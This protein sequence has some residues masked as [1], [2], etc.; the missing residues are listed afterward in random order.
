MSTAIT[1]TALEAS[2]AESLRRALARLGGRAT[3]GDVMT[4]TGLPHSD[5]ETGLKRL[6]E[7]HQG[8]VEVGERGDVVYAFQPR[9]LRRDHVPF[10]TRL[11]ERT[12]KA[13]V[14]GFKAWI[15]VTLVVYFAVFVALLIAALVAASRGGNNR[16]GGSIFGGGRRGRGGHFHF[17]IWWWFWAPDWRLGK[18]YYGRRFEGR[19]GQKVPFYKKVFAFV[20]GPDKPR[21]TLEERDRSVLR[22]VR[23][24]K[25]ALTA[26]ELVQHTG[27]PLPEAEEEM[28]RLMGTY[29]GDVEVST[30]GALVYTFPDLLVSAHGRVTTREPGPAWRRLEKSA[31]FTGNKKRADLLIGSLNGFNLA[32]ALSAPFLIFPPLGLGGALVE[33]G[34]VWIPVVFSAFFFGIPLLRWFRHRAENARR[35]LRNVRKVLLGLVFRQGLQEGGPLSPERAVDDVRIALVDPDTS[36]KEARDELQGLAAEFDAEVDPD[37]S[38][39]IV[40]RFP[41]IRDAFIGS[42]EVRS[43]LKLDERGVGDVVYSS[44]DSAEEESARAM[45]SFDRELSKYIAPPDKVG[46]LDDFEL[47]GLDP[48][49]SGLVTTSP[50]RSSRRRR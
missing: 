35:R 41:A 3:V 2:P 16:D 46:Y 17:P 43:S 33:I 4:A 39:R 20:F 13:F 14:V 24:R 49:D 7:L 1:A 19:S 34:L 9:M 8:H 50:P 10:F 40:Y 21:G 26:T 37:E 27:L 30:G 28:G 32:A 23:S 22:L 25:G 31:E 38:G 18:P 11:K 12:A 45:K 47:E 44:A 36:L 29:G 42:E 15:A 6:L 48:G 5:A